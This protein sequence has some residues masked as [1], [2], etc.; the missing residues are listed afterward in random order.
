[1]VF[2]N[3]RRNIKL[4]AAAEMYCRFSASWAGIR[5]QYR[6]LTRTA[7]GILFVQ[8]L[9]MWRAFG[10]IPGPLT[11]SGDAPIPSLSKLQ[12]QNKGDTATAFSLPL[13]AVDGFSGIQ[14][15]SPCDGFGVPCRSWDSERFFRG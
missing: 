8:I 3:A 5:T 1:M 4:V 15:S 6:D 7:P 9:H 2:R 12:R 13:P 10:L 14:T 11:D